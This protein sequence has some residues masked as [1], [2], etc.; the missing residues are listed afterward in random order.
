MFKISFESLGAIEFGEIDI[1]QLTIICGENNTG[2]TYVTY[3]VYCLLKTWK[4]FVDIN[5]ETVLRELQK[6]GTAKIDLRTV[7]IEPWGDISAQAINKF[8]NQFPKML[9]SN[10]TLLI[11]RSFF[12]V[13]RRF[14]NTTYS[15]CLVLL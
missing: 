3:L 2:K 7:V 4:H 15:V 8:E 14:N 12:L 1:A 6:N 5:L 13:V 11:V 9:A 10:S